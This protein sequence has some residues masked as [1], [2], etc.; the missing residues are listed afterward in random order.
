MS[1]GSVAT[2]GE[3]LEEN[4]TSEAHL[5]RPTLLLRRRHIWEYWEGFGALCLRRWKHIFEEI[6]LIITKK[7]KLNDM[8]LFYH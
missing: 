7:N 4:M 1:T 8:C 2:K 3:P 5:C 6:M